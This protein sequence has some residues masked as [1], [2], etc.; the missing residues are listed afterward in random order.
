MHMELKDLAQLGAKS[1]GCG[2]SGP[3]VNGDPCP[4]VL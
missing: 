3:A 2:W 1:V 4:F